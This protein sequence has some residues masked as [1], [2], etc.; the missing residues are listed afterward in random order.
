MEY[1]KKYNCQLN[2]NEYAKLKEACEQTYRN[3]AKLKLKQSEE[4]EG[5][6]EY[7]VYLDQGDAA[8]ERGA[9]KEAEDSFKQAKETILHGL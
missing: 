9:L 4:R 2:I 3:D 6:L 7:Q 5:V 8:L 1:N